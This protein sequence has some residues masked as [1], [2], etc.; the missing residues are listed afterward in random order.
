M[1]LFWILQPRLR[2]RSR[3]WIALSSAIVLAFSPYEIALAG[4]AVASTLLMV[5]RYAAVPSRARWAGT[6]IFVSLGLLAASP[7]TLIT[8]LIVLT[9]GVL[10]LARKSVLGALGAVVAGALLAAPWWLPVL[11]LRGELAPAATELGSIHDNDVARTLDLQQPAAK[12]FASD[13][14]FQLR[15]A[16]ILPDGSWSLG[17]PLIDY[18]GIQTIHGPVAVMPHGT[19]R[20]REGNLQNDE[21]LPRF[22]LARSYLVHAKPPDAIRVVRQLN[23]LREVAVVDHIPS[24]VLR[25]GRDAFRLHDEGAFM[26]G[27]GG[28]VVLRQGKAATL[29]VDSHGWNLLLSR[30]P[31]WTGWRTYWNGE[32]MPPVAVNGAFLGMFVPPGRGVVEVRY[33]PEVWDAS[34]RLAGVGLLLLIVTYLWLWQVTAPHAG[35]LATAIRRASLSIVGA[36][37]PTL[38]S[39]R[40]EIVFISQKLVDRLDTTRAG[41]KEIDPPRRGSILTEEARTSRALRVAALGL[42]IGYFVCLALWWT[43][44]LP[45]HLSDHMIGAAWWYDGLL[46]TAQLE[47]LSSNLLRRPGDLLE[48]YQFYPHHNVL[49]FTEQMPA[50]SLIARL[51]RWF[52]ATPIGAANLVLLLGLALDGWCAFLL[53]RI[54]TG[55]TAA[56]LLAGTL[57]QATPYLVYELGRVQLVWLCPLPLALACV[58]LLAT[59]VRVRSA[60]IALAFAVAIAWGSCVYYAVLLT[61][62]IVLLALVYAASAI[63]AGRARFLARTACATALGVA[64]LLPGLLAYR[65]VSATFG[66]ARGLDII[67]PADLMTYLHLDRGP[68]PFWGGALSNA[69]K[70]GES[71]LFPGVVLLGLTVVLAATLAASVVLRGVLWFARL[72]SGQRVGSHRATWIALLWLTA[73]VGFFVTQDASVLLLAAVITCLW[74]GRDGGVEPATVA[75]RALC[76]AAVLCFALSLGQSVTIAGTAY[77]LPLR[78]LFDVAPGFHAIRLVSRWG[79]LAIA[80]ASCAGS[81]LVGKL[82]WRREWRVGLPV[83]LIVLAIIELR[84]NSQG[85]IAIRSLV[86]ERPGYR[87]LKDHPGGVLVALPVRGAA[88]RHVDG[89]LEDALLTYGAACFHHHPTVNGMSGFDPPFYSKIVLPVLARFPDSE[90]LALLHTLGVQWVSIR[91]ELYEPKHLADLVAFVHAHP[92]HYRVAV[93]QGDDIILEFVNQG[94]AIAPLPIETRTPIAAPLPNDCAIS[95]SIGNGPALQFAGRKSG[96]VWPVNAPQRGIETVAV[97]CKQP[98][99][100]AGFVL[101]LGGH[102]AGQPRGLEIDMRRSDGAWVPVLIEKN[103]MDLDRLVL[104]PLAD[105]VTK[106]FKS[107]RASAWR[108]RQTGTSV[109][110]PWSVAGIQVIPAH[111]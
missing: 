62:L 29:D 63:V 72:L 105:R 33:H 40:T 21:A 54:I 61:P 6:A 97:D 42:P 93:H 73:L 28:T 100:A 16:V 104:H 13:R 19:H 22:F 89:V 20:D 66:F 92:E 38:A 36:V 46:N 32:R 31:W 45:A 49:S 3:F 87:F 26:H 55:R 77:T 57:L 74:P 58:H 110:D 9:A 108:I 69:T 23:D 27:A 2:R 78:W 91:S 5:A 4:F 50:L 111:E 17:S 70:A 8:I 99:A 39:L 24:K 35:V 71:V 60:T 98:F 59:G 82:A 37:Q 34:I 75:V 94:Q 83:V 96:D 86:E 30:E 44:P 25:I 47:T 95:A 1:C 81:I 107:A 103:A 76:L 11:T 84:P 109:R 85:L 51:F 88:D 7:A 10:G 68:W 90:S 102:F 12:T 56:A 18:L 52:G 41:T 64:P 48:G 80:S 101:D 15:S 53:V 79:A 65:R 14:L 67:A 43:W 106:P